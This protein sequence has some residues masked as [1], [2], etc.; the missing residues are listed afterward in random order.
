MFGQKRRRF[1]SVCVILIAM[2]AILG[3]TFFFFHNRDARIEKEVQAHIDNLFSLSG[4]L[5]PKEKQT[6]I[7]QTQSLIKILD[8]YYKNGDQSLPFISDAELARLQKHTMALVQE[9]P[10]LA[11]HAHAP[12]ED[13]THGSETDQT[14]IQDE[15][16]GINATIEAV[17]ASNASAS[18]KEA[19]LSVLEHRRRFLM[20]H[21]KDTVELQE[22]LM[23]FSKEDPTIVGVTKNHRTG[24]YTPLYPN[25]LTLT[26]HQYTRTDGT[27]GDMYVPTASHATDPEVSALLDP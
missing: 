8:P 27:V 6:F 21:E 16:A 12:G 24:E 10:E 25:M 17:K 22:K 3:G 15:L 7:S 23:E 18:A 14:W 11:T 20:N 1:Y 26:I 4:K 5:T 13:H 19:L 2:A 9:N